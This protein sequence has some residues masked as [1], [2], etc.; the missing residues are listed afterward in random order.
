MAGRT[1]FSP[2]GVGRGRL[3][4][5]LPTLLL[6]A[7]VAVWLLLRPELFLSL[8]M[9]WRLPLMLVSAWALGA[10]FLRPLALEVGQGR[11]WRLSGAPL[12]RWA[13]WGVAG[14]VV[15]LEVWR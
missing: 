5:P 4:R 14:V 13:L 2:G 11:L 10:A 1:L 3:G 7:G 9:A 6:A 8:P 15:C 12:S